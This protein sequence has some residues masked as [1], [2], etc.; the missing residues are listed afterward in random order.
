MERKIGEKVFISELLFPN[1]NSIR[2][3]DDENLGWE[4]R[5]FTGDELDTEVEIIDFPLDSDGYLCVK[6][7]GL[8]TS[9]YLAKTNGE[10][11]SV[12]N[13]N[14]SGKIRNLLFNKEH[15]RFKEDERQQ[16]FEEI[17][18]LLVNLFEEVK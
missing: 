4:L 8:E 2:N 9:K 11:I 16:L 17:N 14:V 6:V 18:D 13:K 1:F 12:I 7:K 15:K 10:K 3:E 5:D